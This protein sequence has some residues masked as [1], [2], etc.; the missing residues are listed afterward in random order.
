MDE[1]NE[2]NEELSSQEVFEDLDENELEPQIVEEE[3]ENNK[4][5][6]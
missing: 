4:E 2:L 3:E 1:D 6:E 5:D